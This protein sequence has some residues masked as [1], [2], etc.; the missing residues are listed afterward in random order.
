MK[1]GDDELD[2][3]DPEPLTPRGYD[4]LLK[5]DSEIYMWS[6]DDNTSA[7]QSELQSALNNISMKNVSFTP[8]SDST[9]GSGNRK[10]APLMNS[11]RSRWTCN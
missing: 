5:S 2:E 10:L 9:L 7:I 6:G 1:E 3:A 8:E 4:E 11:P